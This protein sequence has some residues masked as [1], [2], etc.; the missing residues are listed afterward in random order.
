MVEVVGE[1]I[2]VEGEGILRALGVFWIVLEGGGPQEP[3]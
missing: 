3:P 2:L 1:V